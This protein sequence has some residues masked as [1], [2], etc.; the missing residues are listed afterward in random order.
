LLGERR[1]TPNELIRFEVAGV[2]PGVYFL[3]VITT[4]GKRTEKVV[5]WR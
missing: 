5:V 4:K 3:E 1:F 2:A